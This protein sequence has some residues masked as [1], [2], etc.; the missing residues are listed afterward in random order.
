MK[1]RIGGFGRPEQM[2]D[3]T[4][5]EFV[6]DDGEQSVFFVH[7]GKDGLSLEIS[8]GGTFKNDGQIYDNR[9]AIHPNAANMVTLRPIKYE[10]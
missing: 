1:I 7:I 10:P 3:V 6:T 9:F 8:A 5:L 4:R 2:L